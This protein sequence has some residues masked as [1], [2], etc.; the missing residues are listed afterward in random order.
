LQ[1]K[2]EIGELAEA[3]DSMLDR[4]AAVL[5]AQRQFVA[6]A[7]HELRTP[8]TALGGMVEMLQM[9][10]DRGDPATFRR[11][12]NTMEREIGRLTRLVSDLL[13][14]SRL[15]AEQPVRPALVELAPLANEISNQARLLA[16]GQLVRL[17]IEAQP[18]VV[19]DADRLRQVLL[20]LVDNA[21]SF[22]P[23]GG[24][25][26][27]LLDTVGNTARLVVADTGSG[28]APEVLPR[29]M[30]RFVRGDPSR[31]RATGGSGL[32]LAIARGIVEAHGGSIAIE[33]QVGQGTRVTITLPLVSASQPSVI[34][35]VSQAEPSASSVILPED[36]DASHAPAT[37]SS[38]SKTRH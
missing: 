35:Q 9:G 28:I 37:H 32:G 17:R 3:F 12:L 6:D 21:L 18:V 27:M 22:T 15:E 2:D 33:S 19:G 25:V 13:T 14:L 31:A 29:V 4:L 7:A 34:L 36:E 20:N 23:E 10:A 30:D 38:R 24:V 1:R 5:G 8:L 11:M 26:E 16:H